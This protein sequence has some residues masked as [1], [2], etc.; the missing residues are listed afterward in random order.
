MDPSSQ[1]SV[2]SEGALA[3][4]LAN[5]ET[6]NINHNNSDKQPSPIPF[7]P[8]EELQLLS[9]DPNED[10]VVEDEPEDEPEDTHEDDP[11]LAWQRGRDGGQ[12]LRD[13]PL[14][15]GDAWSPSCIKDG[16]E[17]CQE[18]AF[19]AAADLIDR[20]RSGAGALER[21]HSRAT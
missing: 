8:A 3:S 14:S 12:R 7:F 6:T 10:D 15:S 4:I 21:S 9:E 1:L 17:S 18:A 11:V 16:K 13:S 2:F 19:T 5:A 20:V